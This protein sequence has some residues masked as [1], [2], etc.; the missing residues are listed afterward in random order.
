MAKYKFLIKIIVVALFAL[1]L[2]MSVYELKENPPTWMD[3][4]IILQIAKNIVQNNVYGIQTSLGHFISADFITTGIT[5]VWP[6]ALIFKYFGIGLLQARIIGVLYILL[7]VAC[8]FWLIFKEH[9]LKKAVFALGLIVAFA[10]I[11]GQGK[12]VL[13]EVPGLFFALLFIFLLKKSEESPGPLVILSAGLSAGLCMVTKPTFLIILA[14]AILIGILISRPKF[15][16]SVRNLL[17]FLFGLILPIIIFYFTIFYI[18]PKPFAPLLSMYFG[19]PGNLGLYEVL[20][21]NL[22]KF[23]KELQPAYFLFLLIVWFWSAGLRKKEGRQISFSEILALI[24]SFLSFLAF[25]KS[26][27]YYRYFFPA[28]VIALIY[29]PNNIFVLY[30]HLKKYLFNSVSDSDFIP[31]ILLILFILIQLYKTFFGS[32][33]SSYHD[34]TLARDMET[35]FKNSKESIAVYEVP[36]VVVFIGA[37]TPY[38]QCIQF[39]NFTNGIDVCDKNIIE[40]KF[41]KIITN[42]AAVEKNPS[43]FNL[44]G[45][46]AKIGKKYLVLERK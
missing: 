1:A 41:A 18:G 11:Y 27:G 37:D 38:I 46:D 33:I 45:L 16:L 42:T 25:L 9:G 6:V 5:V 15:L 19:N 24:F 29:F 34:S 4:G 30:A 40:G 32:W 17:V 10:P 2:F 28:Q 7:A 8:S 36:E 14:P 22:M 43:L 23:I 20:L 39:A 35:Y 26:A 13:G 12:N 3:E 21:T 31:K 44:Y